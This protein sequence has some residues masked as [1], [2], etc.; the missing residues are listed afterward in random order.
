MTISLR[1]RFVAYLVV[2]HALCGGLAV[3][4][5]LSE[6]GVWLLAV[7]VVFA[8]SLAVGIAI[9]QRLFRAI[10]FVGDSAQFLQESDYTARFV[11]VQQPEIDRLIGVYNRM[12]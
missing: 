8:A 11:P 1:A 7:E 4:L 12:V 2:V 9:V 10:G 5:L 6:H 3:V